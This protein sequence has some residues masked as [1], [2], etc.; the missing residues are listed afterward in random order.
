MKQDTSMRLAKWAIQ[1][2]AREGGY[3]N[4]DVK[5]L[6]KDTSYASAVIREG[7]DL[8]NGGWIQWAEVD[9]TEVTHPVEVAIRYAMLLNDGSIRIGFNKP[10]PIIVD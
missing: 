8:D 2:M 1:R 6:Q 3:I 4:L 9:I 7:F 5:K 10:E